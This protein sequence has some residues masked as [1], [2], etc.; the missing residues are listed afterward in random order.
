MPSTIQYKSGYPSEAKPVET[1]AS[2][3]SNGLITGVA[4]FVVAS[5]SG[6]YPINSSI[7]SN[8]FPALYGVGVQGLFVETRTVEKRGGLTFLRVGVVGATNPPLFVETLEISP[9]GFNKSETFL[10]ETEEGEPITETFSFDYLAETTSTSTVCAQG[11]VLAI[12]VKNPNAVD[13]WNVRGPGV[14]L[15]YNP[16]DGDVAPPTS[17]DQTII[18]YPR[19][20]TSETRERRGGIVLINKSKQFVYE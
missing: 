13:R 11:S 19:I 20:L 18:A 9:R 17:V 16:E 3:A 5:G 12:P 7:N 14:V 2:V 1:S 8:I 10:P 15:K 4:Q 6:A